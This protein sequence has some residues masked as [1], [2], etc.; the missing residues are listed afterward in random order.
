MTSHQHIWTLQDAKARFS[1]LFERCLK[2]GAQKITRRGKDALI[3]VPEQEWQRLQ[4]KKPLTIK[5]WLLSDDYWRGEMDIPPRTAVP[6]REK[7]I[8]DF[9]DPDFF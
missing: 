9:S 8:P 1:E 5:E 2:E 3:L 4:G 6:L 7:S